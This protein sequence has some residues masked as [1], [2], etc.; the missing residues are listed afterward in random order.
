MIS[1]R[2]LLL[3]LP[4]LLVF[5][6]SLSEKGEGITVQIFNGLVPSMDL[7]LHC[8]SKNDDLGVHVLQPKQDYQFHFH[9]N[10]LNSTL[11]FCS[12]EWGQTGVVHWADIYKAEM[13]CGL[14]ES[15]ITVDG[16]CFLD[17]QTGI[18]NACYPWNKN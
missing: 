13:K 2:H 11:F 16:P 12:F 8:K 6:S 1:A 3:V 4:F 9:R 7:T 10:F 17:D 5:F 14:C 15:K 18:C